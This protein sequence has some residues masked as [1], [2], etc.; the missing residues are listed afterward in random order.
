VG[1]NTGFNVIGLVGTDEYDWKG[2][3]KDLIQS[4]ASGKTMLLQVKTTA[5]LQILKEYKGVAGS[6]DYGKLAGVCRDLEEA[7]AGLKSDEERRTT[8]WE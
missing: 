4:L 5:A 1:V 8:K 3:F 6:V 2:Q 7:Q